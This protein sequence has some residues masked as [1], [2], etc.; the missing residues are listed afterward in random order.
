MNITINLEGNELVINKLIALLKSIP[1]LKIQTRKETLRK[2]FIPNAETQNA[3]DDAGTGNGCKSYKN[4]KEMFKSLG[5]N[6]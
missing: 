2:E 4:S 3:I 6:V 1:D 5:I